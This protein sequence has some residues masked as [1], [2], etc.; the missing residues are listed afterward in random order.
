MTREGVLRGHN[1]PRDEH[2]DDVYYG[3]LRREWER[4]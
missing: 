2:V 4:R 3:V 1:K